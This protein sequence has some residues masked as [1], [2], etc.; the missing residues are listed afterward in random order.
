M[1]PDVPCPSGDVA[2]AA[3]YGQPVLEAMAAVPLPPM[4]DA[5]AALVAVLEQLHLGLQAVNPRAI[6]R[7]SGFLG[8]LLGR[9]VEAQVRAEALAARLGV[10]MLQAD[11]HA[12]ALRHLVVACGQACAEGEGAAS[13]LDAWVR[14]GT[15]QLG[16]SGDGATWQ[17]AL[18]VR[19]DHLRRLAVLRR[20]DAAQAQLLGSQAEELLARHQRIRDTL[21]PAWRQQALS[22]S[23]AKVPDQL[24]RAQDTA[25]DI[26]REVAAMQARLPAMRVTGASTDTHNEGDVQ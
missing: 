3:A 14:A 17:Q 23:L 9:D 16:A 24:R 13:A 22:G 25:G 7:R 10:L 19:L 21:L 12:A 6:R 1:P 18:S 11:R 4:A 20:L 26:A 2:A 8:R 5:M 15:L